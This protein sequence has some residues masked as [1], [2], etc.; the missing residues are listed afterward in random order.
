MVTVIYKINPHYKMRIFLPKNCSVETTKTKSEVTFQIDHLKD[1]EAITLLQE[2]YLRKW[3]WFFASFMFLGIYYS[4]YSF[5]CRE[6]LLGYDAECASFCF[7]LSGSQNKDT[8]INVSLNEQCIDLF[9]YE[10]NY[11]LFEYTSDEPIQILPADKIKQMHKI[12]DR[13]KLVRILP[14]LLTPIFFCVMSV[15]A[16]RETTYFVVCILGVIYSVFQA[17]LRIKKVFNTK[18]VKEELKT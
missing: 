4:K 3:Y 11:Y 1:N 18:S 5:D 6:R 8:T 9:D 13:W 12:K 7:T 2:N 17:L 14:L 10:Q 16:Y 15:F